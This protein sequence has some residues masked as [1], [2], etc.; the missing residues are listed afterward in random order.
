[1]IVG[2]DVVLMIE[3]RVHIGGLDYA[4][5]DIAEHAEEGTNLILPTGHVQG[6][7]AALVVAATLRELTAAS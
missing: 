4:I 1:V 7:V 6:G 5:E 2:S 3:D